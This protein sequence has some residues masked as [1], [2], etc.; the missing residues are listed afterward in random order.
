[1]NYLIIR[2]ADSFSL[3]RLTMRVC[4]TLMAEGVS[5]YL[6]ALMREGSPTHSSGFPLGLLTVEQVADS[7]PIGAH[8]VSPRKFYMHHGI[9]LGDRKVAHYSGFSS[10]LK[11]GPIEVTDL[12]GFAN[13]RPVWIC[14]EP[15][16]FPSHEIARRAR[17]RV[18][19]NQY[20]VLSNNCEHF[21][22]WCVS[23][24]SYSAQVNACLHGPRYIFSLALPLEP[25]FIA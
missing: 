23:G 8:L 5:S 11:S 13:G 17:S 2:V 12:D 6:N 3:L 18:G 4:L 15:C 19:E 7:L 9:H 14:Q 16:A 21:C 22:S 20:S 24:K 25:N 1:V 10:S